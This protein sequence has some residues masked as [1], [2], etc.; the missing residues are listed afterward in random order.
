MTDKNYL[1]VDLDFFNSLGYSVVLDF[2]LDVIISRGVRD[3]ILEPDHDIMTLLPRKHRLA[4][5]TVV[6]VDQHDDCCCCPRGT[7]LNIGN[8]GTHIQREGAKLVWIKPSDGSISCGHGDKG[9]IPPKKTI[10]LTRP[11]SAFWKLHIPEAIEKVAFYVSRPFF[12][13]VSQPYALTLALFQN[14]RRWS[15]SINGKPMRDWS[16]SDL[17]NIIENSNEE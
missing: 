3:V 1:S 10:P 12:K 15:V 14:C 5:I 4:G 6:N 13:H 16:V 11:W 7:S 8:W 9:S 17:L 2:L